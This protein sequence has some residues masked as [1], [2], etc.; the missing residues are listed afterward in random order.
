MVASSTYENFRNTVAFAAAIHE[1]MP[2]QTG[3]IYD[4]DVLDTALSVV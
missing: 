4:E 3:E 2:E 1:A